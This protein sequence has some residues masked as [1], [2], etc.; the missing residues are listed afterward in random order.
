MMPTAATAAKTARRTKLPPRKAP[1]GTR[2]PSRLAPWL[3]ALLFA[4]LGGFFLSGGRPT[5][6]AATPNLAVASACSAVGE[7]CFEDVNKLFDERPQTRLQEGELYTGSTCEAE[8]ILRLEAMESALAR[9]D[10]KAIFG[11]GEER[12]AIV[13]NVEVMPPDG[14][15]AERAKRLNP[16]EAIRTW[17]QEA[18]EPE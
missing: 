8:Y 11:E 13:V 10:E 16:P 9:L 7:D 3:F 2:H 15:K 12:L 5:D 14:S 4:A 17:L 1:A 6:V 18:A